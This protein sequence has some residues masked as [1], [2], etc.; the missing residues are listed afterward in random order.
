MSS[1]SGLLFLA[2]VVIVCVLIIISE[3]MNKEL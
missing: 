1:D 3:G 2:Y